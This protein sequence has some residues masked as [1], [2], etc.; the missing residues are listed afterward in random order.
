[1][2]ITG[3]HAEP[4]YEPARPGDIHDSLADSSRAREAFGY[5]PRYT[6]K[7]GLQETIQWYQDRMTK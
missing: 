7:T 1:M 6:V 4:V 3:I 2:S 5:H